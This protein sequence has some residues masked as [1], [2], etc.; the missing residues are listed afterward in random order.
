[1]SAE[2]DFAMSAGWLVAGLLAV[3]GWLTRVAVGRHLKG[4]DDLS[5]KVD[6]VVNKVGS[7]DTRLARIEGR[8]EQQDRTL[9]AK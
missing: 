4:L 8:F 5:K 3:W 9:V 6:G 1:M 2:Q 7:I